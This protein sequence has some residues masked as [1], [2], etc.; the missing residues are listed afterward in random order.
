MSSADRLI[1]NYSFTVKFDIFSFGFAKVSNISGSA[2]IDTIINGGHNDA[3]VILRKPK[4][5][6]D[7]LVFER[8]T[9]CSISDTAFSY[10]KEGRKIDAI[11]INV[12]CNDKTVR[13]FFVTN[14]LIVRREFAP[15]DAMSSGVFL[16]ALQVAHTGITE[17][18]LPFSL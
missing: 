14:A 8:G 7:M 2:E 15:L 11:T 1:P 18:A 12:K 17:V 3:P 6:P 9:H 4:R 13:M 5:T 10:F 16:E